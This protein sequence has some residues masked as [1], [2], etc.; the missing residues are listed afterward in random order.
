MT[1]RV[2]QA[3]REKKWCALIVRVTQAQRE[4]RWCALT[5]TVHSANTNTLKIKK[6][7]F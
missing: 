1:V 4:E 2:R 3:Q 5:V 6:Q 7:N